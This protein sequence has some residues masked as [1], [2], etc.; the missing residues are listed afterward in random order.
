MINLNLNSFSTKL[1]MWFYGKTQNSIG[2]DFC[3]YF[4]KLIWMYIMLIPG[5]IYL[6]PSILIS[7]LP[8][9]EKLFEYSFD[10]QIVHSTIIY[11]FLM[12]L[13]PI[14]YP[15]ILLTNYHYDKMILN[16]SVIYDCFIILILIISGIC[17]FFKKH[18]SDNIFVNYY[19]AKKE[20]YCPKIKWVNK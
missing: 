18:K 16:L 14:F 17:Y 20:K 6:I 4:R 3:V 11:I 5:L 7:F 8:K 12:S 9:S 1:Y 13:Y 10:V 15:F 19:K 2:D